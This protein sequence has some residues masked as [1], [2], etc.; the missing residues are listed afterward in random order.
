M[1]GTAPRRDGVVH[2][3]TESSGVLFIPNTKIVC[4]FGRVL[5]KIDDEDRATI[6]EFRTN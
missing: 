4:T 2:L 3:S 5:E 1:L 6:P